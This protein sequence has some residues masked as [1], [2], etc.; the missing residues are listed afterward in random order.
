MVCRGFYFK[1]I[2]VDNK[3]FEVIPIFMKHK[4]QAEKNLLSVKGIEMRVNRSVQ[5]EGVFGNEK[6]NRGYTRI[7][8]RGLS[9]SS[10][11]MMLVILGLNIK[12]LFNFYSTNKFPKF[13]TPPENLISQEFK[14]CKRFHEF[15][16]TFN[17]FGNFRH[18]FIYFL[19][20]FCIRIL[21]NSNIKLDFGFGSRRSYRNP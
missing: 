12:K 6:Q 18:T 10:T 11:E 21:M 14:K 7:R 5:V 15:F 4:Q 17:N 13:W 3:I 9:K 8:R 1:N 16:L 19:L 20:C 2:D